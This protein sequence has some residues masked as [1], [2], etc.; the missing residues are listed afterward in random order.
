[1]PLRWFCAQTRPN[2]ESLALRHLGEQAFIAYAPLERRQIVRKNSVLQIDCP[3]FPGY[4]FVQFDLAVHRWRCV[5]STRGINHLLPLY[6]ETPLALPCGLVE[7]IMDRASNL[8][9]LDDW[10]SG[11]RMNDPVLMQAGGAGFARR[12]AKFLGSDRAR[13]K[14]ALSLFGR[15]TISYVPRRCLLPITQGC[16]D[17]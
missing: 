4:V 13:A 1:M 12:V 10:L 11:L 3:L 9:E 17:A 7:G 2:S 15:E 8:E 6:C 14:I 5:N 16:V